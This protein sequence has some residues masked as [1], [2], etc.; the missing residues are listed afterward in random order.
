M[1]DI[2]LTVLPIS[3]TGDDMITWQ[4]IPGVGSYRLMKD[5]KWVSS[6]YD[7]SKTTWRVKRGQ[8]YLL[9]AYGTV[10]AEGV[11][12]A[13][14]ATVPK[15][16]VLSN[17]VVW[18]PKR[19]DSH[20]WRPDM[21][22]DLIVEV[23]EELEPYGGGAAFALNGARNV[24]VDGELKCHCE[25]LREPGQSND[26]NYAAYLL[27]VADTFWVESV[28]LGGPGCTNGFAIAAPQMDFQVLAAK[29]DVMHPVWHVADGARVE[30]HTDAVQ[31]WAGPY[32]LSMWNT[33]IRTCGT[34]IQVMPNQ[35][36][37]TPIGQW[38][39]HGFAAAQ[40]R[41]PLSD[42][43]P[44]ALAKNCAQKWAWDQKDCTIAPLGTP[45]GANGWPGDGQ[46]GWTPGNNKGWPVTGEPWTVS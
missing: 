26:A 44:F 35:Y 42:E 7:G 17:P 46:A 43:M 12:P 10:V 4:Q 41:N 24:R 18:K 6:S 5:G 9:R 1:L 25:H 21:N 28:D 27:N 45:F 29:M 11:H 23:T 36:G 39:T 8:S 3:G 37:Y 19:G 32:T 40:V 38:L 30:A 15:P 13:A 2:P 31:S 22:T 16:P 33:V 34:V 20:W 14:P